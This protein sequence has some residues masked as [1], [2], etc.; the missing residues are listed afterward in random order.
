MQEI[1]D[2]TPIGEFER[3]IVEMRKVGQNED[4]DKLA[5]LIATIRYRS[6][7]GQPKR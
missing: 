4:A 7:E 1:F 5:Y 6:G 3:K 2:K